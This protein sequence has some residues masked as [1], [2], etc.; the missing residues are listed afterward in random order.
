MCSG[1][2]APRLAPPWVFA[3]ITTTKGAPS[4]RSLQRW[5]SRNYASFLAFWVEVRAAH[6]FAQIA[7]GWGTLRVNSAN[8]KLRRVGH[9]P[10]P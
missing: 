9:P 4:L 8:K 6:P 5:E 3:D 10:S 7:K 2:R 1:G